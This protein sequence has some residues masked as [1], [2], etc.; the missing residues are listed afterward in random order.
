MTLLAMAAIKATIV[1]AAACLASLALRRASSSVRYFLWSS[2]LATILVIPILSVSV[3]PLPVTIAAPAA[4]I[5]AVEVAPNTPVTPSPQPAG[6]LIPLW[7]C[8]AAAI[9]LRSLLGHVRI[10]QSLRRARAVPN[11]ELPRHVELRI[12]SETDVPL[13]YGLFRPVI[14]LPA[15]SDGW[16]EDRRAVVLLHELTHIRRLDSLWCLVSQLAC[17]AYWFHPL[18][19]LAAA[20]FRQEQERSCDDAVIIA[21]ATQSAYAGHLVALAGSLSSRS[22]LGM[23]EAK[24]LEQRI[25]ALLDPHRKRRSLSRRAAVAALSAILIC[26]IPFAAMRARAQDNGPKASVSGTVRDPSGAVVPGARVLLKN[27]NGKNQETTNA[28]AAG[29]YSFQSIP[30]GKYDIEVSAPGFAKYQRQAVDVSGAAGVDVSLMVGAVSETVDV[31]GKGPAPAPHASAGTPVRI[32]V[33]GNVQATRLLKQMKPVY[34]ADAQAAGIEGTV[35][36]RAVISKEGTLLNLSAINQS[37]DPELVQAAIDAVKQWRYQPTLLNGQP[38]E[39]ITTIT[40]NFR[41]EH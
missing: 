8:G 9:L 17:A 30:A 20:R 5:A 39:V 29:T 7:L 37:V 6:W 19:W 12:S 28:N 36:L 14:I 13:S 1:L 32:R 15:Q 4:A 10:Q 33:G 40:V 11:T 18:V 31:V 25:R 26:A 34:P 16:S 24:G 21:G 27:Q 38:V 2:A 22:A 23:A 41:L 3:R 35:L